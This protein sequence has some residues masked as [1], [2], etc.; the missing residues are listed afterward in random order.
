MLTGSA[1]AHYERRIAGSA[2]D[3]AV[4][5]DRD[6]RHVVEDVLARVARAAG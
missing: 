1:I 5:L 4:R 3:R 2:L 6:K